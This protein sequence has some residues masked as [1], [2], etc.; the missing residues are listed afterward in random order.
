MI[1]Y[2]NLLAQKVLDNMIQL[3]NLVIFKFIMK[4]NQK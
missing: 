2:L 3:H 4:I 1:I